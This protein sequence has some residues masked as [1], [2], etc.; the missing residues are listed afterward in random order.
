MEATVVETDSLAELIRMEAAAVAPR[1]QE[2]REDLHRHPELRFQEFRTAE[3]CARELESLGIEVRRGVGRTGVVGVLRG[4]AQGRGKTV[5][6]RADMDAL[7]IGDECGKPYESETPGVGHLCGHDGHVAA[8]LG[9]AMVLSRHRDR[10]PGNVKFFFE[11]AEEDPAPGEQSGAEAMIEDG[12]LEDP[13]P[14]AVFSGHFFPEWPASS[15]ALRAGPAF[16][17]NDPWSLTIIG[18]RAHVA[19]PHGGVDAILVAGHIVT[20]LQS[21]VSQ[22]DIGEAVSMHV[23]TIKGGTLP[24]LIAEQ[25]E[26]SGS[27]RISD[28]E[29]RDE[30]AARFE[31]LVQNVCD[32]FGA[33]YELDYRLRN[34]RAIISSPRE[35]EIMTEA[36]REVLGPAHTLPM[37][38]PRLAADTMG[39]WLEQRPGVFFMVGSASDD[40]ATRYPSHHPRFDIAPETWPAVVAGMSMTAIRYLESE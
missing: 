31:R 32:S 11:P 20:A 9:A 38:L 15:I 2:I 29:M 34:T 33:T 28:E 3:M 4:T 13:S 8:L 23:S 36:L 6:L 21:L 24:N 40:P 25:V 19:A 10:V 22:F 5:A 1:V 12:A 26:M 37:H 27:F 30:M 39:Y 16:T 17:G 14:D 7:A 18:R 35:V